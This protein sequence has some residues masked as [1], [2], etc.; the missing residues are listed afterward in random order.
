M[1][2]RYE[3]IILAVIN[4]LVTYFYEKIA[5][6]YIALWWKNKQDRVNAKV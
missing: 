4:G 5:I 3:I 6:W 2:F 1:R